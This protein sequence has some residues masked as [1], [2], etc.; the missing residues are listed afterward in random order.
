MSH[1]FTNDYVNQTATLMVNGNRETATLVYADGMYWWVSSTYVI[2]LLTDLPDGRVFLSGASDPL[3]D[4]TY[5]VFLYVPSVEPKW[6]NLEQ[7]TVNDYD[8]EIFIDYI[9]GEFTTSASFYDALE[10]YIKGCNVY[11]T[12]GTTNSVDAV[13][14]YDNHRFI[15]NV[16]QFNGTSSL[17]VT[18]Y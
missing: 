1:Y 18:V 4:G 7:R 12:L 8:Y 10:A 13:A 14:Y 2:M 11:F 6:K 9:N 17:E 3:S 16:L 15:G 5:I